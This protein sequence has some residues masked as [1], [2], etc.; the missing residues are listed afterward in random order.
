MIDTG[1][2]IAIPTRRSGGHPGGL[3]VEAREEATDRG[4]DVRRRAPA[5]AHRRVAVDLEDAEDVAVD[6]AG[7]DRDEL[8]DRVDD[9]QHVEAQIEDERQAGDAHAG[10]AEDHHLAGRDLDDH[11]E[12]RAK[13][14]CPAVPNDSQDSFSDG[15]TRCVPNWPGK[16]R[17]AA[18][19]RASG[20]PGAGT[21]RARRRRYPV[22]TAVASASVSARRL[23]PTMPPTRSSEKPN[24]SWIG[25]RNVHAEDGE[26][27]GLAVDRA[28]DGRRAD[29]HRAERKLERAAVPGAAAVGRSSR[30]P[31]V[32]C[33]PRTARTGSRR[34]G[35]PGTV[36]SSP[37]RSARRR[38]RMRAAG[39][40]GSTTP[41]RGGSG[42]GR[43]HRGSPR[44]RVCP[45]PTQDRRAREC[46]RAALAAPQR[47]SHRRRPARFPR[48]PA[49][50]P[51]RASS[52]S[53][54]PVGKSCKI[55]SGACQ[56]GQLLGIGDAHASK[57][58]VSS[59]A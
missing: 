35:R 24:D 2:S 43:R 32:P 53:R 15:P 52:G 54:T 19:T 28:E 27:R 44:S 29:L 38:R 22:R 5:H 12:V 17:S 48:Q 20:E 10:H 6:E 14:G 51:S 56:S 7:V 55:G 50:P 23:T 25:G 1:L 45:G 3:G 21:R 9:A 42:R 31:A 46:R 58:P 18:L 34:S 39:S 13:R 36:R 26:E 11:A 16:R 49:P 37:R 47:A 8:L 57:M 41:P 40:P 59:A 33:R 30:R 4:H